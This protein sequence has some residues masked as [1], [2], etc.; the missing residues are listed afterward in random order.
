[1]DQRLQKRREASKLRSARHR[2]RQ[3]R[4][5]EDLRKETQE[6]RQRVVVSEQKLEMV[7]GYLLNNDLELWCK[8]HSIVAGTS[9]LE[10]LSPTQDNEMLELAYSVHSRTCRRDLHHASR[11]VSGSFKK[12]KK[13]RFF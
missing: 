5:W 10:T 2:A 7:L 13:K 4:E 9:S 1:M 6:L 11:L 3:K 12:R 8:I